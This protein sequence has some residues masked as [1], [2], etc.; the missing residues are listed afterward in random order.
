MTGVRA[1]MLA[2][3]QSGRQFSAVLVL[4][5]LTVLGV[6][7]IVV[8][9]LRS[10]NRS[11]RDM[12]E[13]AMA[14]LNLLNQ[15]Q[16]LTQ[17]ARR[18]VLYALTTGDSNRQVEYA[19]Q[20]RAAD[21]QVAE[22]IARHL[23]S[24]TAPQ[25][26]RAG[27]QFATDWRGYLGV[28]DRV[29]TAILEGGTREATDIDLHEGI[30]AF[31][32]VRD[33]LGVI[34]GLYE[35]EAGAE[36]G[37]LETSSNRSLY[38]V[39]L[40]LG[41]TQ[42]FAIVA[43]RAVQKGSM[44]RSVR[45][46][47]ERLRE[48]IASISEG[49]FVSDRSGRVTL[50]NPVMET[51]LGRPSAETVGR[52][53]D[54]VIG[55]RDLEGLLPA[56]KTSMQTGAPV[57]LRDLPLGGEGSVD[58]RTFE[59]RIFPFERGSTVFL[60]D[61]TELRQVAFELQRAK[62]AA[63]AANRSKSEFLA[64]MSHEI[65]TP[66]NGVIGMTDLV[67]DTELT[68]EQREYLRIVKSSADALMAVI[69]D[70]LDFSKIEAG[71]FELDPIDFNPRDAVGDTADALA[72]R[73][74]QKSLEL[75]VDVDATVPA[76][77]RGDPGRLRQ[78]LVNLIGNAIKFTQRGEV[79]LRVTTEAATPHEVLLHFSVTDTGV[80]I[81]LDRQKPIFEAF[82]QADG[83]TTRAY[84]G[85]GLGLTIA[86]Q[87]VGLMGG[88]IWVESEADQG[89]TFH[90]TANFGTVR[91][92]VVAAA[93][94]TLDV[95]GLTAL[96]VDDNATNRRLLEVMLLGWAMVPTLVPGASEALAA[97]RA[98]Q[99][100]ETP[101]PLV[102]ADVQ[103]PGADGFSLAEAIK[104]EAGIASAA[105]VMLTS[106]GQ[107]GDA[108]RCRELGIAAY[109]TKPIR[110]KDLHGAILLALAGHASKR[111]RPALITR[112]SL[113]ETR[114]TGRILLVEDNGVNRL[115]ASRLLERRGHTVVQ[116]TNG[117]EALA[118][119]NDAAIAGFGCVL[120]DVQMPE[121]DGF[122]CT[123]IIREREKQ[124]HAHLAIIA[125]TAHAMKGDEARC[126]AAGMDGYLSKPL[127]PDEFFDVIERH[128]NV[129]N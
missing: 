111:D 48:I 31:N 114:R 113:R 59:A 34:K 89:S 38:R 104:K 46:S 6:G 107:P 127:Q 117:H 62:E 94:D 116:A 79:V 75:I 92:P 108:A 27:Q 68:P 42:L 53:L 71:K 105:V 60:D 95:R 2:M 83:S 24:T 47:E 118:I 35:Q 26:Q 14:G 15:L 125:M 91:V 84:G 93:P 36:I 101:F 32:N 22:I 67:L 9:D 88:R 120:M 33:D 20:S 19:D 1:R 52:T 87:L 43:V 64:N 126:L 3:L 39:I 44:L 90:F 112:H 122:E 7:L 61:V 45:A 73:A 72:L 98:A 11:T 85:T 69:N 49:M 110:S 115:V 100:S 66:M 4:I 103:M 57:I 40:I 54:E 55:D 70:I 99:E 86:S 121:M 17:E 8:R 119:L 128:L 58:R 97:L 13:H 63:E 21:A 16:Y 129:S 23:R 10:S 80:G 77:V 81:P 65:R 30:P 74:H 82:T 106:G 96:I 109:L 12:Y 25:A 41:L 123:A 28:R 18:S 78:I 102:L 51:S 56:I 29:I 124:T 37:A 5:G 50:W 76:T